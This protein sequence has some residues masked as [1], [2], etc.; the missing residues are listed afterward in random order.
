V[1]DASTP[2][3]V[4]V[5]VLAAE[6]VF[7][8]ALT[9]ARLRSGRGAPTHG[10]LEWSALVAVHVALLALPPLEAFALGTRAPEPVVWTAVAVALAAQ[11]LR[12]W[13]ILSLG[14]AWNARA[15]VD[16][17]LGVVER[18]PYR[19]VRHPNYAAVFLEFTAVPLAFGA[20]RSWI[21]LNA[22]HLPLIARRIRGEE[23]LL[24][25]VPGY[26]ERMEGKGRFLPRRRR[27]NV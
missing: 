19:W 12:Y 25:R 27:P 11:A 13:C 14:R 23:E 20:W 9:R 16:P 6:R 8:L 5:A 26:S 21:L 1:I 10:A 3:L 7:E 24:R 2:A 22:L 17:G 4:L 18:G 15:V